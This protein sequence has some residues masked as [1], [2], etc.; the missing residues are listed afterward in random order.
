MPLFPS[1]QVVQAGSSRNSCRTSRN[2]SWARLKEEKGQSDHFLCMSLCVSFLHLCIVVCH[3]SLEV[4]PL[5][6]NLLTSPVHFPPGARGQTRLGSPWSSLQ[7]SH[8]SAALTIIV[9]VSSSAGKRRLSRD[10]LGGM[11]CV[12]NFTLCCNPFVCI[13]MKWFG[14]W[15]TVAF[16]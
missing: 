16:N 1:L 14:K 15:Y 11:L 2:S 9:T 3:C 6:P 8:I 7:H 4:N 10:Y 12:A 5:I 13:Q